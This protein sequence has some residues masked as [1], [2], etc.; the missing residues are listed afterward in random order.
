MGRKARYQ[1]SQEYSYLYS[2]LSVRYLACGSV[3]RLGNCTSLSN[4]NG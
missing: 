3:M 2:W 4:D 1:E